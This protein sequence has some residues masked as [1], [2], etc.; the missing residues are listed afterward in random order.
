M[1]W[2]RSA[3][4]NRPLL[5]IPKPLEVQLNEAVLGILATIATRDEI[6]M[7]ESRL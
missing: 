6:A 4:T 5:S 7:V 2:V 3:G 1:S